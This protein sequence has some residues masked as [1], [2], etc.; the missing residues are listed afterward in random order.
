[1]GEVGIHVGGGGCGVGGTKHE[2]AKV[3]H[4]LSGPPSL[5]DSSIVKTWVLQSCT[6]FSPFVGALF[7]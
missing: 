4:S 3:S 5:E 7:Y 1:M 2:K 6:F